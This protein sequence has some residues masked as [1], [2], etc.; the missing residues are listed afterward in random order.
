MTTTNAKVA[1]AFAV[2]PASGK[3]IT[4]KLVSPIERA[5][6]EPITEITL[7]KPNAGSLRGLKVPDLVSGDVSTV[8]TLIPRISQP[9]VSA[10]DA[11]KLETEDLGEIAGAIFGFF[12]TPTDKARMDQMM[13]N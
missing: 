6:G 9:V 3:A 10:H 5:N 2:D 4:V 12:M 1:A 7:V 8:L 13:G 11:E